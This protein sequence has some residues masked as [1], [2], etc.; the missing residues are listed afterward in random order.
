ML[1]MICSLSAFTLMGDEAGTVWGFW[2]LCWLVLLVSVV[3]Y[4]FSI[5]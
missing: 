2:L 4:L 1:A 3:G 5:I